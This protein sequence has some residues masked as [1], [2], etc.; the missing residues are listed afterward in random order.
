MFQQIDELSKMKC[1][2]IIISLISVLC[3]KFIEEL[4]LRILASMFGEKV[5]KTHEKSS[6]KI[7]RIPGKTGKGMLIHWSVL[8]RITK[9]SARSN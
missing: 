5:Y 8:E 7:T 3:P 1:F 4:I 2:K 6:S 9:I